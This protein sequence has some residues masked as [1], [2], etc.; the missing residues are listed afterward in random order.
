MSTKTSSKK[1]GTETM[2]RNGRTTE[3]S[4][5]TN[6]GKNKCGNKR[7][8]KDTRKT[9]SAKEGKDKVNQALVSPGPKDVPTKDI[10]NDP[11]WRMYNELLGRQASGFPFS[12]F[13][14]TPFTV[15]ADGVLDSSHHVLK[16]TSISTDIPH[17][18]RFFINP[19]AGLTHTR[20]SAI[21]QAALRIYTELSSNNM[22]TTQYGPQDVV[23]TMLALSEI[24]AQ[25]S[26][27]QR[28]L[29]VLGTVNNRNWLYPKAVITAMEIDYDDLV[30]NVGVYRERYNYVA[31][32]ASAIAFP[33][34]FDLFKT[35]YALFSDLYLDSQ[36]PMAQTYIFLPATTWVLD[37]QSSQTG[38]MLK[39]TRWCRQANGTAHAT[40]PALS[41]YIQDLE[42]HIRVLMESSTLQYL[43]ADVL[44]FVS[45]N[46]GTL[47][48][49]PMVDNNYSVVPVYSQEAL[50][51]IENAR[52]IGYPMEVAYNQNNIQYTSAANDVKTEAG[53]NTV[54]Y[55]PGFQMCKLPGKK[56]VTPYAE[57]FIMNAFQPMFNY[58][59][60]DPDV[61]TR[62]V[63]ARFT[64]VV[65]QIFDWFGLTP[66][67]GSSPDTHWACAV[68]ELSDHYIAECD[69]VE[70]L[71]DEGRIRARWTSERLNQM[72][73]TSHYGVNGSQFRAH[74]NFFSSTITID[75]D[76]TIS[77]E[78][79][80]PTFEL[81][82]YCV[83][84]SD[85]LKAMAQVALLSLLSLKK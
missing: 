25:S 81:D 85:S 52:V 80:K 48:T 33:A 76:N 46:G 73:L 28:A 74:P 70:Y 61:G 60:E 47:F 67:S 42:D 8:S 14:G 63:S 9:T 68:Y 20:V 53:N 15:S 39:T 23:L 59:T 4:A 7:Y 12:E 82:T 64:P 69:I 83:P 31:A 21:N 54:V 66:S 18:M 35:S 10:V 56:S 77:I 2:K 34:G 24:V 22:K 16:T 75:T 41:Q 17:M 44:K 51:I 32:L 13:L 79:L 65:N 84:S 72:P 36:D 3:T 6:R 30:K 27:I 37:E 45:N 38:S 71:R 43:Y 50:T 26:F 49:L 58:H 1:E 57:S 78:N 40:P 62:I 11:S 55:Y 29:G 5:S 19:S